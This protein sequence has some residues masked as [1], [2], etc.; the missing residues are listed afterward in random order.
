[1]GKCSTPSSIHGP[2]P[3]PAPCPPV[4]PSPPPPRLTRKVVQRPLLVVP[5]H[6]SV[7][8]DLGN[9]AGR[10]DAQALSV[11]LDDGLAA[12]GVKALHT[13][14]MEGRRGAE[15]GLVEWGGLGRGWQ[16]A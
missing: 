5:L 2:V 6:Q 1:M 7:A 15:A 3:P 10:G 9:D 12:G 11:T 16:H 8:R 4:L 14:N 13:W